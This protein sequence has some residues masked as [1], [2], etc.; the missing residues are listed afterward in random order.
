L[1]S[2]IAGDVVANDQHRR[3]EIDGLDT[4]WA[5]VFD[6]LN[7]RDHVEAQQC[8][9]VKIV[10]SQRF[11]L[12]V[13]MDEPQ[14]AKSP[15]TA[16][17][18]TD[19]GKHKLCRIADDDIADSAVAADKYADLAPKVIGDLSEVASQFDRDYFMWGNTA[20]VGSFQGFALR[21]LQTLCIAVDDVSRNESLPSLASCKRSP[22]HQSN[23]VIVP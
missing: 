22:C 9:V 1:L 12:E 8:Q 17:Q 20:S 4:A 3:I 13:S 11:T 14:A 2:A 18:T 23:T 10:S 16:T 21:G 5:P 6:D 7:H 15:N 19:V